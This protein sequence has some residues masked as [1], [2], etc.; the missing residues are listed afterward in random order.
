MESRAIIRLFSL[1]IRDVMLVGKFFFDQ[2]NGKQSRNTHQRS[3][4]T[5]GKGLHRLHSNAL[6]HKG[7][8]PDK[9]RKQKEDDTLNFCFFHKTSQKRY[10]NQSL[11]GSIFQQSYYS[12]IS[13]KCK[14]YLLFS[15]FFVKKASKKI[16]SNF[17][18][19]FSKRY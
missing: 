11:D 17:L 10:R 8:T 4:S 2:N 6:C 1:I 3:N 15:D 14:L 12:I 18:K 5:E 19:N 16:L 7:K 13:E 9:C